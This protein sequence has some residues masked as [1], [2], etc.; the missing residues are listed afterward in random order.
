MRPATDSTK[1]KKTMANFAFAMATSIHGL[2]VV[3]PS[4]PAGCA[5]GGL[6][7]TFARYAVEPRFESGC[8]I[9]TKWRPY[10]DSNPGYCRE[11][12]VS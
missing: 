2:R 5:F 4:C 8:A 6:R 1:R 3:A 9:A 11:R 10:G 12:A 7:E